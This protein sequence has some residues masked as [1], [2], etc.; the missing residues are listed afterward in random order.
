[1]SL[2]LF[3]VQNSAAQPIAGALLSAESPNGAWQ[4]LTDAEGVFRANLRAGHYDITISAAGYTTRL[5]PADLDLPGT[6][7]IGLDPLTANLS[8]RGRDFV[9]RHGNVVKLNGVDGFMD[10]RLFLDGGEEAL[11]PFIEETLDFGFNARRVFMQGSIKQNTVMELNPREPGYDK[12]VRPYVE[13][14]NERGIMPILTVG[15]DNQDILS[16]IDH[17]VR[18]D[19]LTQGTDR[20]ISFY[21]ERDKNHGPENPD[22]IPPASGLWSRGSLTTNLAPITPTGP[23]LE[24]H[25]VR[26]YTTAMRDAIASPIEL[27]EV[28]G[29]QGA[30]LI[31]EPGRMGT[32]PHDGRFAEPRTVYEYARALSDLCAG[33]VMHNYFGQRGLLMDDLTRQCADGWCRG[34]RI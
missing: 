8:V 2:I 7:T 12:H 17:W 10:Y 33:A 1:M 24:F 9:D 6:I 32:N 20:I 21:N 31:D 34:M 30:L 27:F 11:E 23:V 22:L 26:N 15:V 13:C 5:L 18:I 14:M 19:E 28:Q 25:P 29:Y 16:P 3:K 4:G